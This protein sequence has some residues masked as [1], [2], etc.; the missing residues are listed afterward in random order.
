MNFDKRIYELI[1]TLL[2]EQLKNL[3][4]KDF[5]ELKNIEYCCFQTCCKDKRI[6]MKRE[7]ILLRHCNPYRNNKGEMI[8]QRA[9]YRSTG[10][11]IGH[12]PGD[13]KVWFPF[14]GITVSSSSNGFQYIYMK[15]F[16]AILELDINNKN[17]YNS[18]IINANNN[19]EENLMEEELLIHYPSE[20]VERLDEMGIY[21]KY[22]EAVATRFYNIHNLLYSFLLADHEKRME[23]IPF[24]IIS[25][26]TNNL[27]IQIP[28]F[29]D[30]R[31]NNVEMATIEKINH[32]IGTQNILGKDF[33][34]ENC[35]FMEYIKRR[36]LLLF[37]I[38]P[39]LRED[40]SKTC[41]YGDVPIDDPNWFR[42]RI[43]TI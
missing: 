33:N 43:T 27:G 13:D 3:T 39:N 7:I 28:Q 30:I 9:F 10:S 38:D 32:M 8:N 15:P 4:K 5:E 18:N 34:Q 36:K 41:D 1:K 40:L 35:A 20:L 14:E 25:E 12:M 42:K 16:N 21:H 24:Y 19:N 22:Q 29:H 31:K 23:Y 11:S 2:E 26:K 17:F 37:V 6:N